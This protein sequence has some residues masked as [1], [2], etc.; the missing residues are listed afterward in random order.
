MKTH[1][2]W[3][4]ALVAAT[5]GACSDSGSA[6]TNPDAPGP[7]AD[8]G[9]PV[10]AFF[11]VP[12]PGQKISEF[13]ALPFPNDLRLHADGTIDLSDYARPSVLIGNLIDTFAKWT[14]GF[15]TNSAIYF[16]FS[17][18]VDP[19][20]LPAT[21]SD[22]ITDGASAYLVDVDPTSPDM[23]QKVP[24]RFRFEAEPQMTIGANWLAMQPYPGFPLRPATKYMAVVTS[25]VRGAGGG[26]LTP[27][28]AARS[29]Y[30][31]QMPSDA[32][33]CTV[34]TTQDPV[35]L[36][37]KLR[38]VVYAQPEPTAKNLASTNNT[39]YLEWIGTYDA[40]NFQTGDPPYT[41]SGGQ[42]LVDN[43]GSPIVQR[44]EDIRFAVTVPK[45]VKMPDT[46]WPIV[47]Y[48]HGTG[49]NYLS[50]IN[51]GTAD[52]LAVAGLAAI[53]IDQV[54]HG[55]RAPPS[56]NPDLAFFN[57]ENPLAGRDNVRQGAL[58][59]FQL[60]RLAVKLSLDG[61][62]FDPNKI[63]F[64]GHSQG[65]LTGPPFLAAEPRVSGAVLSGA[66]ALLYIALLEKTMPVDVAALA[67]VFIGDD[68]LDNFDPVLNMLQMFIEGGDPANYGPLLI[69]RPLAG[70]TAKNIYQSEGFVDHFAPPHGIEAFAVSMGLSQV[71]NAA[72]T[73]V[74]GL[75]LRGNATLTAPVMNNEDGVTGVLL[76]YKQQGNSD[77]HFVVFDV[78]AAQRQSVQFLSTLA[79]TGTATLVP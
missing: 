41:H 9:P 14:G 25:R 24:V 40:P 1:R 54:L 58:D 13:Y 64:F 66:G 44:V 77:G 16:R 61:N 70:V 52:R 7:A 75:A 48:A 4:A 46:G 33:V 56:T 62:V 51:D 43:S 63:Y 42:I 69:R 34:F 37:V 74:P 30:G 53:S 2:L 15:G 8:A 39:N 45:N 67:A 21:P 55:T 11:E 31:A 28:T 38:T 59:D 79:Q 32:V 17:G 78:P 57:F 12:S 35:S 20:T 10:A 29:M 6:T 76:Q 18:P 22:S 73:P 49:G 47:L 65:G 23:G 27:V 50:F 19:S 60:L 36:M 72:Y 3:L 68:P 71:M 5:G 26:A